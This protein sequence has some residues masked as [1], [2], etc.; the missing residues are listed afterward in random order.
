MSKW[1]LQECK[2]NIQLRNPI[3]VEGLPGIGNIGK[4]AVDFI[5]NELEPELIYK[6]NSFN[7]PPS[8][9]INDNNLI[10]L[11]TVSIYRVKT[12][13]RDILFL[14]GDFQPLQEEASYYFS[15]EVLNLAKK[16]GCSEIITLGG[17]G[18]SECPKKISIFGTATDAQTLDKYKGLGNVNFNISG[19]VGAIFGATGLLL[20]LAPMHG[21]KGLGLLVETSI[22]LEHIALKETKMLLKTLKQAFELELNIEKFESEIKEIKKEEEIRD[23][24]IERKLFGEL[25]KQTRDA[26]VNYFG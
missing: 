14:T 11:P 22:N 5:V 21:I 9:L 4:L 18:L 7:F 10:S 3:L 23:K 6:I 2:K 8:V 24:E 17:I 25:K 15:E 19:K 1:I 26:E 12:K 16:I 20:G 13:A